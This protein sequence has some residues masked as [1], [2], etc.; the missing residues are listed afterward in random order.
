MRG[1]KSTHLCLMGDELCRVVVA[2]EVRY[3]PVHGCVPMLLVT[4]SS[5]LSHIGEE[6]LTSA[7][8]IFLI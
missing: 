1:S 6:R 5:P 4:I 7:V 8:P 2:R 3:L